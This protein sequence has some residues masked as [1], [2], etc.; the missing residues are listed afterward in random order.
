MISIW[1][2]G[3]KWRRTISSNFT[4]TKILD[5]VN[6][7]RFQGIMLQQSQIKRASDGSFFENAMGA[8][9]DSERH[10]PATGRISGGN[11]TATGRRRHE[12]LSH[13]VPPVGCRPNTE[14]LQYDMCY[15]LCSTIS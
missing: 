1:I 5:I 9:F 8:L 12:H 13:F 2:Q 14:R 10:G 3:R 11:W 6:A 15:Y 7:V 4:D